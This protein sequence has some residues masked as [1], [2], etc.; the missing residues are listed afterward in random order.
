M[1]NSNQIIVVMKLYHMGTQELPG[2]TPTPVSAASATSSWQGTYFHHTLPSCCQRETLPLLQAL[3]KSGKGFRQPARLYAI[4]GPQSQ[5]RWD[6]KTYHHRHRGLQKRNPTPGCWAVC[7]VTLTAA[8]WGWLSLCY[9]ME[10]LLLL[11]AGYERSKDHKYTRCHC[12]PD[13]SSLAY[14]CASK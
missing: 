12:W 10:A 6:N 7:L 13:L 1:A 9:S 3:S 2:T 14:S 4:L 5:L 11:D 8:K